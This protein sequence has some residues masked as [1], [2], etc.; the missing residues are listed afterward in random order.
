TG[1]QDS[2]P[3]DSKD[4]TPTGAQDSQ[5]TNLKDGEGSASQ[6]DDRESHGNRGKP[7]GTGSRGHESDQFHQ[8]HDEPA[9]DPID[10][11]G[12]D[13]GAAFE[14]IREH[15]EGQ[16]RRGQ[17]AESGNQEDGHPGQDGSGRREEQE[18][19]GGSEKE[20]PSMLD[21]T[22]SPPPASPEDS[23]GSMDNGAVRP[24]KKSIEEDSSGQRADDPEPP[25]SPREGRESDSEGEEGGDRAG[26]GQEG[27]GQKTP[28]DG[29]G[30]PGQNEAADDG[31][32]RSADRGPG[33]TSQQSGNKTTSQQ[34]T[35]RSDQQQEGTGTQQR[36]G[37]QKSGGPGSQSTHDQPENGNRDNIGKGGQHETR[38]NQEQQ[39]GT[40]EQESGNSRQ[41]S[42]DANQHSKDPGQQGESSQGGPSGRSNPWTG[43]QNN[44]K[45]I[46]NLPA[47]TDPDFSADEANLD[48]AQKQTNLIL[49]RLSDQLQKR[50]VDEELLKKLGWSEDDLRRFVER[51]TQRKRAAQGDLSDAADARRELD[52]NLRSLGL[53]KR[54]LRRQQTAGQMDPIR[55]LRDAYRGTTPPE[56]QLQV[57]EYLQGVARD[58]REE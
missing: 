34:K 4:A 42:E 45:S 35:G 19:A 39:T 10:S 18:P 17:Q 51:W 11:E 55:D 23:P 48:Y 16:D 25:M 40:A 30:S 7:S 53:G 12:S 43:G 24:G 20:N 14:T 8:A 15:L 57:H 37:G 38:G 50:S 52:E 47:D 56:F 1:T 2:E 32:G 41:E 3:T 36:S 33:E 6:A 21:R 22:Q 27:S 58:Q 9:P 5:S 26:G 13:D 54:R 44:E 29:T 46:A 49:D 31:M 28:H